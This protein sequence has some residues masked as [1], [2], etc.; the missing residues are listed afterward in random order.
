MGLFDLFNNSKNNIAKVNSEKSLSKTL[1]KT[2]KRFCVDLDTLEGIE[3]IPVRT[4][5]P[6][7][8]DRPMYYALQRKATEHKRNGNMEL[9]IACLRKSNAIS[10]KYDRIP[11]L[12]KDYLRLPKYIALTGDKELAKQEEAKIICR[13]S[14]IS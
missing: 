11:L 14:R 7:V 13:S 4:D 3:R 6:S 12:A 10:D 1:Q 9:A 8:N 5:N 2:I